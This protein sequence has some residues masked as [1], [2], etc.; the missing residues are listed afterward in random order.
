MDE[1][2]AD[3]AGRHRRRANRGAPAQCAR[4]RLGPGGREHAGRGPSPGTLTMFGGTTVEV[5]TDAE[6]R[7][8]LADALGLAIRESPD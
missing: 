7:L 1:M 5:R 6:G 3:M 2:K 4:D 8:V